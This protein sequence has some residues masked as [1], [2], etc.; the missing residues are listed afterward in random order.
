M[1]WMK[2][3]RDGEHEGAAASWAMRAVPWALVAGLAACATAVPTPRT[4]PTSDTPTSRT[5]AEPAPDSARVMVKLRNPSVDRAAVAADAQRVAGVPV[6]A[7]GAVTPEWQALSL[8]CAD[9]AACEA[10]IDRLR[11][12]TGRYL[13]VEID[14]RAST[15]PVPRDRAMSR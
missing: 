11:A 12:D 2:R 13:L 1:K 9:A 5:S 10:A 14:R 15:M 7:T 3:L 8:D 4:P 6:R